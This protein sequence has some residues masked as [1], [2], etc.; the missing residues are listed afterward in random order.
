MRPQPFSLITYGWLAAAAVTGDVQQSRGRQ[1]DLGGHGAS[2]S[3]RGL[4]AAPRPV[5]A[6]VAAKGQGIRAAAGEE[7]ALV[8]PPLLWP[9]DKHVDAAVSAEGDN[10][11]RCVALT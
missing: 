11:D 4:A 2:E 3:E 1:A 6:R 8:T 10:L 7:K 9:F 5:P